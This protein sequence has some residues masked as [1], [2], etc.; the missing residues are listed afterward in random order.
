M[1]VFEGAKGCRLKTAEQIQAVGIG[2]VAMRK[3][4]TVYKFFFFSIRPPVA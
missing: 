1:A 4:K 2:E 3:K